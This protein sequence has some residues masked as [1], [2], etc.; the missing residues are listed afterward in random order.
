M[1]I[2]SCHSICSY[3]TFFV[4]IRHNESGYFSVAGCELAG[5]LF[6]PWW[7]F[8][9]QRNQPAFSCQFLLLWNSASLSNHTGKRGRAAGGIS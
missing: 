7:A 5:I 1:H 8:S 9:R 3:H 6:R 4:N 2:L